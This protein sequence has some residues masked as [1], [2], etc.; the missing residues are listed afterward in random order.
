MVQDIH[1]VDYD[2]LVKFRIKE[3]IEKNRILPPPWMIEEF[4]KEARKALIPAA[5]YVSPFTRKVHFGGMAPFEDEAKTISD[6]S[7]ETLHTVGQKLREPSTQVPLDTFLEQ[8]YTPNSP[9]T[10]SGL[11]IALLRELEARGDLRHNAAIDRAVRTQLMLR[12][13]Y[14][15]MPY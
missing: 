15:G 14:E 4:Q 11:P 5:M 1:P 7:H 12:R 3:F 9:E 13:G 8:Y 10:P 2:E 6:L